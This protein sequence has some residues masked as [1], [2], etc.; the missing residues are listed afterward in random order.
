MWFNDIELPDDLL[1]AR[2][3]GELVVFAGAGVSRGSPS[4]LPMF[5]G[6][7]RR[8]AENSVIP[9]LPEEHED[10]FLG[11]LHQNGTK[12]HELAR[13]ILLSRESQPHRLHNLLLRLFAKPEAVRLVTTN[14]DRHFTTVSNELWGNAVRQYYGP[15]LPLGASFH[16]IVYLHG[17]A[18]IDCEEC[19]LTD[20]DF[21]KAYLIEGWATRFLKDMFEQYTVLFIGYSHGDPVMNY[22]AKGLPPSPKP[23][24]FALVHDP[25]D[26][27]W[28]R[29]G[30]Q[31]VLY[32]VKGDD[33]SS[34]AT[35]FE[36]WV[37][38]IESGLAQRYERLATLA[39]A[40]SS[41]LNNDD[42]D[43]V[44]RSLS[45]EDTA[46]RFLESARGSAWVG[47]MEKTGALSELL[48]T[49]GKIGGAQEEIARWLVTNFLD[50]TPRTLLGLVER[51]QNIHPCLWFHI[52]CRLRFD[53]PPQISESSFR[54]W[55]GIL[56]SNSQII[57][58]DWVSELVFSTAKRRDIGMLI[59]LMERLITP[60][61][62]LHP[63]VMPLDDHLEPRTAVTLN[64]LTDHEDHW[65][66]EAWNKILRP[67]LPALAPRLE[68][69]TRRALALAD[70]L[71]RGSW[72]MPADYDPL[73]FARPDLETRGSSHADTFVFV[74]EVSLEV[75]RS[76]LNAPRHNAIAYLNDLFE[77]GVPVLQR[78]AIVGI[79]IAPT[80]SADEKVRWFLSKRVMHS[81]SFRNETRKILKGEIANCSNAVKRETLEAIEHGPEP[82]QRKHLSL[83]QV[84]YSI[85]ELVHLLKE[86]DE[87]WKELDEPLTKLKE[88]HPD[89]QAPASTDELHLSLGARWVDPAEG[90]NLDALLAEPVSTF[91]DNWL[92]APDHDFL[93]KPSQW[94]HGA[95]LPQIGKRSQKW[96]LEVGNSALNRNISQPQVWSSLALAIRDAPRSVEDWREI[97]SLLRSAVG[98]DA[99]RSFAIET[100][101]Y[102]VRAD[103]DPLPEILFEEADDLADQLTQLLVQSAPELEL[104]DDWL[105][106]T[107]NQPVGRLCQYWLNRGLTYRNADKEK[108]QLPEPITRNLRV[109]LEGKWSG[110]SG[111]R[112]LCGAQIQLLDY[113]DSSLAREVMLPFFSWARDEETASHVWSGFLQGGQWSVALKDHILEDF[114]LTMERWRVLP[115][116]SQHEL[117]RHL[118]TVAALVLQNPLNER[119]LQRCIAPLPEEVLKD[120]AAM[121]AQVIRNMDR[122]SPP[123]VWERW[124]LEYLRQRSLGVPRQWTPDE[125]ENVPFWILPAGPLFPDAV[126][127]LEKLQHLERV[128]TDMVLLEMSEHAEIFEYPDACARLILALTGGDSRRIFGLEKL[129]EIVSRVK[130]AGASQPFK[131]ALDQRMLQLGIG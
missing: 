45:H 73:R 95:V 25:D 14:F 97:L 33:H 50:D 81:F 130:S 43:F 21:G 32:P 2:D 29:L 110:A 119:I 8:I 108:R 40:D 114:V 93:G 66:R 111:A 20:G 84:D 70:Q 22:L 105:S 103:R 94:A 115:K 126:A 35:L 11:A 15:A 26:A 72:E 83:E 78:F 77:T 34:L 31:R 87:S 19:V 51:H 55:I 18:F 67:E 7:V 61:L 109:L 112:I 120:F 125:V 75:I 41:T 101:E 28:A 99:A 116:A 100:L 59:L 68:L 123:A 10:Q 47:W 106:A 127:E 128:H 54:T 44:R 38:E 90:F 122:D 5:P 24:R 92:A 62:R 60:K 16:G 52:H 42:A 89:F 88:Q 56:L 76:R 104:E 63:S 96:V 65:L 46:R 58:D 64:L 17:A 30:I 129:L 57:L 121:L 118:A 102:G 48:R 3:E 85:F 53:K 113:L 80:L 1:R 37:G 49:N 86:A 69:I 39:V 74:V 79:R 82:D 23:N 36:T 4:N 9:R 71:L 131:D 12:V 117:G 124:L 91:L 27:R 98:F 107:I 13:D 6:L